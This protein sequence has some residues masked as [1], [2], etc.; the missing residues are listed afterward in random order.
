MRRSQTV[1]ELQEAGI[2]LVEDGN[3]GESRPRKSEFDESGKTAFIRAADLSG[4]RILFEAA[5]KINEVAKDRIR[6]GIGKG[7]DILLS[8]KGT[9]GKVAMAPLD[10]PSFVCSPQTTFY[11]VLNEG[12]LDREFLYAY[13]RSKPFHDQLRSRQ[14]ETDMAAYVSL[15]A[16]RGLSIA[17]PP[18]E[19]QRFIGKQVSS[20]DDKIETNRRMNAVLEE[21]ARAIFRAWFIDFEPVK[22]KAAGATSFPGMPQETFDQLP[23]RLTPSELGEIPEGWELGTVGQFAQLSRK[24]IKPVEFHDQVVEHFSIPAYDDGR[25]PRL[26][27]G[28]TIKSNKSLVQE[29]CVL[30][31]KLNP[32][33]PRVW[34]PDRSRTEKLQLCSTEFLV[35]MPRIP[36]DRYFLYSLFQSP[37]FAVDLAQQAS[38]TSNS[39]QRI[40][41]ADLLETAF[42]KPPEVLRL[43]HHQ[44]AHALFRQVLLAQTESIPLAATRDALL[45][46]LISGELTVPAA[47]ELAAAS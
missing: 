18:I 39:H 19:I 45:P 25:M 30:I 10:A 37:R 16:Q 11:R 35:L 13:L 38:G 40:K 32:K 28:D 1:I 31:S 44:I 5:S 47:G 36:S 43:A 15:T 46:K 33:T 8:H 3:H 22:A 41:P 6:K 42:V 26:D 12:A 7:G 34:M 24:G 29:N 20:L 23:N 4:G 9:V 14:N 27:S 17:L 2:L 21:M